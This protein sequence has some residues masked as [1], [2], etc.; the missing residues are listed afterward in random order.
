M[1][2]YSK[3]LD[4]LVEIKKDA[5]PDSWDEHWQKYRRRVPEKSSLLPLFAKKIPKGATIIEGG[6]GDGVHTVSLARE[7]YNVTGIDYA[8]KT[9]DLLTKEHPEVAWIR[10][11]VRK[12]DKDLRCDCYVSM[13]VVEHFWEGPDDIIKEINRVLNQEG[14]LVISV[15]VI[16]FIRRRKITEDRYPL[17]SGREKPEEFYQFYYSRREMED[18]LKKNGFNIVYSRYSSAFKALMEDG[19]GFSGI[20]RMLDERAK[21]GRFWAKALILGLRR[22]LRPFLGHSLVFVCNKKDKRCA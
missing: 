4:R 19:S 15:P 8:E 1:I 13:G 18:L 10:G 6:C 11:D 21:E 3:H 9:I 17:F 5:N 22:G 14:V 7:G 16:N 20:F 2:Y 12:L